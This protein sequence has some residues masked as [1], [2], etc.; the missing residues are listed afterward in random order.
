MMTMLTTMTMMGRA[1]DDG[2]GDG[3]DGGGPYHLSGS[4]ER[5][6]KL[7]A[8]LSGTL[9]GKVANDFQTREERI[10]GMQEARTRFAT[11]GE[12]KTREKMSRH[13]PGTCARRCRRLRSTKTTYAPLLRRMHYLVH[14]AEKD[15]AVVAAGQGPPGQPDRRSRLHAVVMSGTRQH[16]RADC[17]ARAHRTVLSCVAVSHWEPHTFRSMADCSRAVS[18]GTAYRLGAVPS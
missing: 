9:A 1:R 12:P 13:R 18:D 5:A 2:D 6:A 8:N 7:L 17:T 10:L 11:L 14:R 16:N 3:G 15:T 4:G